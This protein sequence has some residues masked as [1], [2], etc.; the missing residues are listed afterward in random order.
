MLT[1]LPAKW[2]WRIIGALVVAIV[3]AGLVMYNRS[4]REENAR[5]EREVAVATM[6][7]DQRQKALEFATKRMTERAQETADLIAKLEAIDHE[8]PS[9]DGPV[10]PVLRDALGRL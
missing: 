5:L 8:D 4:L 3:F 6:I 7:A 9:R 1:L 2:A 10:A